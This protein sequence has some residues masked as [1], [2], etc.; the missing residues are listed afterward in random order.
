MTKIPSI[1]EIYDTFMSF[2]N[3]SL[4]L[5]EKLDNANGYIKFAVVNTQI[6]LE[7]FLKYYFIRKG[8]LDN[9]TVK[10]NGVIRGFKEFNDILNYYFSSRRWTYG[11]KKELR[12][13]LEARNLIV[14]SGLK[15]GWNIELAKYIIKCIFFMQGTMRSEFDENLIEVQYRKH[16]IS[17]NNIWRNGVEEFVEEL[18][19]EVFPCPDCG[20]L[21]FISSESF[22]IF[23]VWEPD[24][25][26][27]LCCF[28][29]VDP[30][31]ATFIECYNCCE[32]SYMVEILNEQRKSMY[33]AK[34]LECNTDTWVRKCANCDAFY[35]PIVTD[36]KLCKDKYLCSD[37][38]LEMF[39]DSYS[40]SR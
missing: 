12:D 21:A 10:K 38:C 4:E 36:E 3:F 11:N 30:V 40:D 23:N 29:F 26:H 17:E 24:L 15:A 28:S 32:N 27:C 6:T 37:E 5:I 16:K 8:N 13:I 2:L 34:C 35:H 25:R 7:L 31:S 14:H 22:N 9:I 20:A 1:E 33:A 18:E 19:C 39:L